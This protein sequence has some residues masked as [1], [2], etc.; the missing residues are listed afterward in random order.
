VRKRKDCVSVAILVHG[1]G[2]LLD[3]DRD[4]MIRLG[5]DELVIRERYEFLSIANDLLIALWFV[6]GSV[7][8]FWESTTV[9]ATWMFLLGSLE[10]LARP[11]IRVAR[12]VHV[13]RLR[14]GR[15]DDAASFD[16]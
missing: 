16:Y 13:R 12:G 8:F 1:E 14:G 2:C 6:A 11:V 10:F 3:G 7:L 5:H 9:A 4:L 15:E